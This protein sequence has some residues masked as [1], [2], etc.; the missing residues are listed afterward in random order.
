MQLEHYI[1]FGTKRA[2]Q[3]G[4]CHATAIAT[5][6]DKPHQDDRIASGTIKAVISALRSAIKTESLRYIKVSYQGNSYVFSQK[7]KDAGN[8]EGSSAY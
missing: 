3:L 2:G 5:T 7:G 1:Q 4:C 8:T 6:D